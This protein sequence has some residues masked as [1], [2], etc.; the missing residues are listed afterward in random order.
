MKNSNRLVG[1]R[2]V[3]PSSQPLS[4]G[5]MDAKRNR[6]RSYVEQIDNPIEPQALTETR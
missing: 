3:A 1:A 2:F 4:G 6:L 5:P